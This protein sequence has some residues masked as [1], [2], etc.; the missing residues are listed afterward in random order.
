MIFQSFFLNGIK[1]DINKCV[2][3][4]VKDSKLINVGSKFDYGN[5]NFSSFEI[6]KDVKFKVEGKWKRWV[7]LFVQREKMKEYKK[8]KYNKF[9]DSFEKCVLEKWKRIQFFQDY[10]FNKIIKEFLNLEEGRLVLKF[11]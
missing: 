8:E 4:K 2:D 11:Q 6:V 5:K 3:F 1:K 9:G 10:S 7:Y